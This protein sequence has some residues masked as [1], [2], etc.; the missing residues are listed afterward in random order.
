M[1]IAKCSAHGK[2]SAGKGPD[3][4][5]E[6]PFFGLF[7]LARGGPTSLNLGLNQEQGLYDEPEAYYRRHSR[8]RG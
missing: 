6:I 8:H 2:I 1:A 4:A 5:G 3:L 7:A